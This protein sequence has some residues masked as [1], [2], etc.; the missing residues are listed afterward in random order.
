MTN[1]VGLSKTLANTTVVL[2]EIVDFIILLTLLFSKES[3]ACASDWMIASDLDDSEQK[4]VCI[5]ET[6][7]DTTR[8]LGILLKFRHTL[9]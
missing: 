5:W 8:L 9:L 7:S 4:V 1:S 6:F 2:K 3:M